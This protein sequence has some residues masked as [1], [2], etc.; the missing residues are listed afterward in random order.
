LL[1]APYIL[2]LARL[3]FIQQGRIIS[4]LPVMIHPTKVFLSGLA[5]HHSWNYWCQS[6]FQW[7]FWSYP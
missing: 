2:F 4:I 3:G 5:Y 7:C 6:R 1:K